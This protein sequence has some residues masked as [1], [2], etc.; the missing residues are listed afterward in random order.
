MGNLPCIFELTDIWLIKIS[1][2]KVSLKKKN[3][4]QGLAHAMGKIYLIKN[5]CTLLFEIICCMLVR[6]C[7][8]LKAKDDMASTLKDFHSLV[9]KL[10]THEK[11]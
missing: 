9:G 11:V 10:Y 8:R 3:N 4:T 5:L 7:Q 2:T 1:E 6:H